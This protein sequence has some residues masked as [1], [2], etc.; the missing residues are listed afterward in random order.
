MGHEVVRELIVKHLEVSNL[1]DSSSVGL[2]NDY[3]DINY[4]GDGNISKKNKVSLIRA[5]DNDLRKI[6]E[7]TGFSKA[8]DTIPEYDKATPLVKQTID[9][10]KFGPSFKF[11]YQLPMAAK[12]F[13]LKTLSVTSGEVQLVSSVAKTLDLFSGR[14]VNNDGKSFCT[15]P[16]MSSSTATVKWNM[17]AN[18]M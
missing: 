8:F 6:F 12:I 16:R 2:Q 10:L 13:I 7:L 4:R 17:F 9:Y 11:V 5:V 18:K 3:A 15:N 14:S 1:R